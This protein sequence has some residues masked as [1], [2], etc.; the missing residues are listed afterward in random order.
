VPASFLYDSPGQA[1]RWLAY[2]RAWSPS[3]RDGEV[4]ALYG[5]S[6][7]FAAQRL[8]AAGARRLVGLGCG[9][10]SKDAEAAQALHAA[11]PG[12]LHYVAIDASAPLVAEAMRRMRER[13]PGIACHPLEADLSADPPLR[14]WM[15]ARTGPAPSL[16]TCFGMLPNLDAARFPAYVAGLLRGDDGLLISANL[17]PGGFAADRSRILAQYDN[18]EA[19]A[20]YR[21]ALGDLG[22]DERAA[23]LSVHAERTAPDGS[24]WRIT[25]RATVRR[26]VALM[27]YGERIPLA[28]GQ[29][30]CLFKSQR[31]T[32]SAARELLA[33]AGL[34][35]ATAWWDRT[36]E[37][38]I[39]YCECAR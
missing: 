20:W 23:G 22:L 9:G 19:R 7:R 8:A 37:E 21:G 29:R 38:G 33:G 30:L 2:H 11:G 36:G 14:D 39:F 25:V 35:A 15:D 17:S 26:P 3:R 28:R 18:P 16:F 24:A 32:E 1:E 13:V 6:F 5:H 12:P 31:F 27:A 34:G 4:L 10:G